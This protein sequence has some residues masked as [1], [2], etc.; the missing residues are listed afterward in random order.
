MVKKIKRRKTRTDVEGEAEQ[1]PEDG[2]PSRGGLRADLDALADDEFTAKTVKGFQ[3]LLDHR[4]PVLVVLGALLVGLISVSVYQRQTQSGAEEAS[5]G[6]QSANDTY[7]K[8]N[9]EPGE[10][11]AKPLKGE[12][13]TGQLER[14]RDAFVAARNQHRGNA[15]ALLAQMGE[16]SAHFDLRDYDKALTAY[17]A[18]LSSTELEPFARAIA[19]EGKAA[20]LESKGALDDAIQAWRAMEALDKKAYGLFAGVRIGRILEAQKKTKE[21][22]A[23]YQGLQKAHAAVLKAF[24]NARAKSEIERR[25]Q[26][27][28]DPS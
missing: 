1:V 26:V 11:T 6:F 14:A 4:T 3:W 7:L 19:L 21:A 18:V 16:A 2:V 25:I 27:L 23:H 15:V 10:P 24:A 13:R 9:G 22:L 8:V 5:A 20:A 28:G 12:A 17:N